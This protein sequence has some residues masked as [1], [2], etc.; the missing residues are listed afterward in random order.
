MTLVVTGLCSNR[1]IRHTSP[2]TPQSPEWQRA[3]FLA[4]AARALESVLVHTAVPP[5]DPF[6]AGDDEAPMADGAAAAASVADCARLA[7]EGRDE[8]WAVGHVGVGDEV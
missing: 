4:R 6:R 8:A 3:Q 7:E 5:L 1:R 2:T